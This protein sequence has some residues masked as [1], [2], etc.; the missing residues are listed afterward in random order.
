[1]NLEFAKKAAEAYLFG[2]RNVL[3]REQE[4]VV[5]QKCLLN[6]PKIVR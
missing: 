4:Q 5:V 3:V 1:M 2:F 6:S